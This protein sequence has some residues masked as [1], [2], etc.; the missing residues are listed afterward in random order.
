MFLFLGLFRVCR[1]SLGFQRLSSCEDRRGGCHY[2]EAGKKWERGETGA[3]G[4]RCRVVEKRGIKTRRSAADSTIQPP[5]KLRRST[6]MKRRFR[7]VQAVGEVVYGP[8]R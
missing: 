3:D 4:C 6:K 7:L 8:D 1:F 5:L 2:R